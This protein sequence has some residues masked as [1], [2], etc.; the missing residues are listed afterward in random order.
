MVARNRPAR[1]KLCKHCKRRLV[2]SRDNCQPCLAEFWIDVDEGRNTEA[3]GVAT[4]RIAAAKRSGRK[5]LK[6]RLAK[7]K[8]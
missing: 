1:R 7:S 8:R 5:P 2:V 6:R 3:N 4:G